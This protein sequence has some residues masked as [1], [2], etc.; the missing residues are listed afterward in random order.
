MLVFKTM[1]ATI[2]KEEKE[3]NSRRETFRAP[4]SLIW[5]REIHGRY[6]ERAYMGSGSFGYAERAS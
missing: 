2:M 3:T 4:T 6:L 1:W 5:K